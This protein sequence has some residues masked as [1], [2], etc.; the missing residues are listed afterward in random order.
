MRQTAAIRCAAELGGTALLVGFGTGTI[1]AAAR[2]GGVPPGVMAVAWFAAVL[3]PIWLFVR[4]SGAHLNPVVTVAL[5]VSGRIAFR[6]APTYLVGQFTGAFVGSL[7]VWGLL[8]NAAH[9]GATTPAI[10]SLIG[11]FLAEAAFT[12]LL[13]GAVF[14]LSDL[15]EGRVRWRLLL[16][17]L[18]VGLATWIIG[19]WT[20][21]SL[22]L[23]R[24]LA[25]AVLSSTFTDL[26]IYVLAN[27]TGGLAVALVWRPRAV[28]RLDRGPGRRM[29]ST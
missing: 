5:A 24:S 16:P 13:V 25:P 14:S 18:A 3:I 4:I 20:G 2:F 23:A 21:S 9:L 26:W 27:L 22:N 8:G 11:V 10:P 28:D 7:T 15:G 6:E 19:P 17:P 29:V 12:A 1:V